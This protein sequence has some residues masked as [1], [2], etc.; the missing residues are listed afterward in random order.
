MLSMPLPSPNMAGAESKILCHYQNSTSRIQVIRVADRQ[1][2]NFL[3]RVVFPGQ[4]LLFYASQDSRLQVY[5]GDAITSLL[6]ETIPCQ[7]LRVNGSAPEE[8]KYG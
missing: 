2:R 4:R 7:Q 5:S 6:E 1:T 3:E 8:V